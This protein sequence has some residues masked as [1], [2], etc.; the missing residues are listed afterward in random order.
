[1][2]F[3]ALAIA[4]A[5]WLMSIEAGIIDH[6]QVVPFPQ[7]QPTT[8]TN[9][10]AIKFKPQLFINNGCH[11]YPAVNANG[12]TGGGLKPKGSPEGGC[13]GSGYG[14]QVYGRS[15]WVNGVW[16]IMYAWYFPKDEPTNVDGHRHDW[17]HVV[18]WIDNPDVE[19]PKILAMTPSAHSGYSKYAPP[20]ADMV[21]GTSCM[22]EYTSSWIFIDHHL[23]GTSTAGEFQDLIMWSDLTDAA[24][25]ALNTNDFGQVTLQTSS[26]PFLF[27]PVCRIWSVSCVVH[28]FCASQ[29]ATATFLANHDERLWL[30]R[31][32]GLRAHGDAAGAAR[33]PALPGAAALLRLREPAQGH[34]PLPHAQLAQ[35]LVLPG[36]PGGRRAHVQAQLLEEP[37]RRHR[38]AQRGPHREDESGRLPHR[39]PRHGRR[40][41]VHD[42]HALQAAGGGRALG[43][44]AALRQAGVARRSSSHRHGHGQHQGAHEEGQQEEPGG[45]PGAAA[46]QLGQQ[47]AVKQPACHRAGVGRSGVG[48]L[49]QTQ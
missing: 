7:S 26:H 2:Y 12:D 31:A 13:R 44:P 42:A 17:E 9:K 34:D 5:A 35:A 11:P 3:Q 45:H 41:P 19:N 14:S 37:A 39:V 22:V 46:D 16:A 33:V 49:E 25:Y 6:D 40:R 28:T 1:M 32:G 36:L 18:V 27:T 29:I 30:E 15:T 21:T 48:C 10:A 20:P 23:E 38:P 43:E 24:R 47:R 8:I 4:V